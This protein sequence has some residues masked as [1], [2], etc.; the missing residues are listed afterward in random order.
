MLNWYLNKQYLF[1]SANP[2]QLKPPTFICR[3][4]VL[5]TIL[6]NLYYDSEPWKL[7]VIR[8]KGQFYLALANRQTKSPEDMTIDEYSG[9]KFESL[10]TSDQPNTTRLKETIPLENPQHQFHTVQYW[11]FGDFN[12]LYSNEIDGEINENIQLKP[13][14]TQINENPKQVCR[15]FFF[16]I[17]K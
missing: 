1:S 2:N 8:I 15:F 5:R 3:R 17:L 14:N 7:L 4:L 16:S 10:F 9:F 11:Q 6:A 13:T 12:L